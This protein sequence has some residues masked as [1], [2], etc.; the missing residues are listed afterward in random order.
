MTTVY[1]ACDRTI[2]DTEEECVDHDII[3]V[4]DSM[5]AFDVTQIEIH[6]NK[7]NDPCEEFSKL[8]DQACYLHLSRNITDDEDD[9][10]C[11]RAE[12]YNLPYEAGDY[13][14]DSNEN[15]WELISDKI[16][17]LNYMLDKMRGENK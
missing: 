14:W 3:T 16:N 13:V 12:V 17:E 15:G 8:M 11:E 10:I 9:V 7:N 1:R 6:I 4:C 5:R 2:F